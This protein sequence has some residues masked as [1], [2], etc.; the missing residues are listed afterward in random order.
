M[1]GRFA[2]R[3]AVVTGAGRGIGAAYAERL[4]AEGAVVV[5]A[6]LDAAAAGAVAKHLG[7]EGYEAHAAELDIADPDACV[8]VID[9]VVDA[10]GRLDILVNN[11]ALYMGVRA[12]LAEDI[13]IDT[14][15]RIVE[16]N[17]NGMFFMCRAAIPPMK[18]QR[19]G[20]I[21]NQ[22]SGS[23]WTCPP[24]MLHYVTTKSTAI[25]MTKILAREL[26]GFGIRVNALA[27]GLTETEATR[28][29]ASPQ[30]IDMSIAAAPLG[31]LA[32]PEDLCG[33]L[34]FLCSDDAA[35]VTGQTIAVNGGSNMIP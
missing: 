2:G 6:D 22:T 34:A 1:G 8:A 20:C 18:R 25:P 11:A 17:V 9:A 13:D 33:T 14:W 16:V 30:A 24:G 31:R 27:P 3:I 5:L 4:A 32:T 15:R 26:G 12:S 29:V 19:S 7:G 21:V 10:H 23:I 35:F 28:D